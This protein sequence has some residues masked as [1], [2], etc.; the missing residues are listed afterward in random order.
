M[1]QVPAQDTIVLFLGCTFFFG[2]Q[3]F[4]ELNFGFLEHVYVLSTMY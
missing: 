4:S 3:E 2:V 1:K